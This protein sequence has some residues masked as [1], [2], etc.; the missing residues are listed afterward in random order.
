LSCNQALTN[1]AI[2]HLPL[3][4]PML[5][6]SA[7]HFISRLT[8]EH[9]ADMLHSLSW[10]INQQISK[11]PHSEFFCP[12]GILARWFEDEV[13]NLT[14]DQQLDLIK[15]IATQIKTNRHQ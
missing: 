12:Q 4:K 6:D 11:V 8:T 14:L 10:C 13:N 9:L 3:I 1:H 5:S 7:Q 2:A 15:D